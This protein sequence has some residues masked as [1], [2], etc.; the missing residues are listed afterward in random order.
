MEMFVLPVSGGVLSLH[1]KYE[2]A[3]LVE[4]L[5]P[6]NPLAQCFI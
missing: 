2:R 4:R 5:P 1:I 3:S 6:A